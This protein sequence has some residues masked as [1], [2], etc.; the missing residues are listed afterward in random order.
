MSAV[1][2]VKDHKGN[3]FNVQR[4]SAVDQKSLLLILGTRLN[5]LQLIAKQRGDAKLLGDTNTIVGMLMGLDEA[6]FDRVTSL[7]ASSLI[8]NG[9]NAPVDIKHFQNN[10]IGYFTVV[11]ELVRGNL[12][13]FFTW[14]IDGLHAAP[15]NQTPQ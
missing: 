10:M 11:A 3:Q 1:L 5:N 7:V 6:T 15:D 4:A 12:E 2:T 13:D 8:P 14:L 9:T